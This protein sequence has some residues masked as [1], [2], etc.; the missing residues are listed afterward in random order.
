MRIIEMKTTCPTIQ[1]P[2][3]AAACARLEAELLYKHELP[4]LEQ[5]TGHCCDG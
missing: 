5:Y 4:L 3:E 1:Q 2:I